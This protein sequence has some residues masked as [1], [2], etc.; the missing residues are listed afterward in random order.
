MDTLQ[1]II[2]HGIAVRQIPVKVVET[3]SKGYITNNPKANCSIIVKDGREYV[4]VEKVP[5]NAGYWMTQICRNTSATM[6]WDTK[7]HNLAATLEESVALL[8]S[9]I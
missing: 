1:S 4:R 6:Q 3:W 5:E 2:V 8:L 9:N 7:R